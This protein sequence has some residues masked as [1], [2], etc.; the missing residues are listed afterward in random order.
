MNIL[1]EIVAFKKTEV[2]ARKTK[3]AATQLEKSEWLTKPVISITK[4]LLNQKKSGIIAEHKRKSPSKGIINQNITVEEVTTGYVKAK[5]SALSV[6]TDQKYFDGCDEHL[7]KARLA[8]PETPILRKD[9]MIDEYQIL[10]SRSLG[11]DVILLIA[12][13]LTPV[14]NRKLAQFAKSIGLET[15]LEVHDETELKSHLNEFIDV[16][17]VNNRNLK[18]M[19]TDLNT[20][21]ELADLIPNGLP[22]VSESGISKPE[23]LLDLKNNYGY[24]GFLIGEYFMLQQNPGKAMEEFVREVFEKKL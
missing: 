12:S 14:E 8:N 15:L 7:S 6:L 1:E 20:S 3:T 13:C 18:L 9:F 10:E 17:G 11:A 16:V 23:V 24:N 22:K 2:A 5:A 19:K 21:R 4:A